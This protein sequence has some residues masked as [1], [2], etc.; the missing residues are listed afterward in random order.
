MAALLAALAVG[1]VVGIAVLW[2]GGEADV[3]LGP[4][5]SAGSERAEIERIEWFA[6]SIGLIAAAP[7]TAA[8]AAYLASE[9]PPQ[10]LT[11]GEQTP[12]GHVH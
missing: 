1:T 5:L 4:A 12:A 10:R 3:E 2:P 7:I 6:C 8:V 9:L 11:D